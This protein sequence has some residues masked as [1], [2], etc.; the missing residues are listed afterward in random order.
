MQ[1]GI[2]LTELQRPRL[3]TAGFSQ[4]EL[5]AYLYF[6]FSLC[7]VR[8]CSCRKTRSGRLTRS[9]TPH[10]PAGAFAHKDSA[11]PLLT[12]SEKILTRQDLLLRRAMLAGLLPVYVDRFARA[13]HRL[14]TAD[15]P[16]PQFHYREAHR[17][18]QGGAKKNVYFLFRRISPGVIPTR[19]RCVRMKSLAPA[20]PRSNLFRVRRNNTQC[21]SA[22]LP[23]KAE[24]LPGKAA[25]CIASSAQS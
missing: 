7:A 1:P 25:F 15:A 22:P 4:T 9:L 17:L 6:S 18:R 24:P 19:A 16:E 3:R 10:S 20:K 12:L 14:S 11:S 5:R 13:W 21:V 23:G 8:E 2:R